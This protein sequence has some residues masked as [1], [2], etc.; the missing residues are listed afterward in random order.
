MCPGRMFTQKVCWRAGI[1]LTAC[2][3]WAFLGIT[4]LDQNFTQVLSA[5][6]PK[7]P[8]EEGELQQ[9]TSPV[10]SSSLHFL[11]LLRP[12]SKK[13]KQ[14]SSLFL[15]G[16]GWGAVSLPHRTVEERLD[17][18]PG[19]KLD[20]K[21]TVPLRFLGPELEGPQR[22]GWDQILLLSFNSSVPPRNASLSVL[23]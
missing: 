3:I 20:S 8:R 6:V 10:W 17:L 14:W 18:G 1:L 5:P 11:H 19:T 2:S 4:G 16:R 15:S 23:V 9:P 22:E 21:A 13:Y 12:A 7:G